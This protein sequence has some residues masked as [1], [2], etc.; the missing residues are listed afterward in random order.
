MLHKNSTIFLTIIERKIRFV[1]IFSF[2]NTGVPVSFSSKYKNFNRLIPPRLC[3]NNCDFYVLTDLLNN[4]FSLILRYLII[5]L[6]N[7]N[8][9]SKIFSL[10][11]QS[12]YQ[13]QI[14][15]I[16]LSEAKVNVKIRIK[17][18]IQVKMKV[19]MRILW[20]LELW[21][22]RSMTTSFFIMF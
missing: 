16:K 8:P 7:I 9:G 1:D 4:M 3:N 18:L 2:Y 20:H 12:Q 6:S 5:G 13:Y 19:N 14:K 11:S 17:P 10:Q 15:L 22:N 21:L